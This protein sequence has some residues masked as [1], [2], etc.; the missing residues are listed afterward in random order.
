MNNIRLCALLPLALAT[1]L[2][3]A[4]EPVAV[5]TLRQEIALGDAAK[6]HTRLS[7]GDMRIEGTDGGKVEVELT[8]TCT[9]VDPEVCKRRA[10]WVRLAPRMKKRELRVKLKKTPKARLR[11]IQAQMTVRI[12]RQVPVE[13][14]VTAGTLTIRGMQSH[15]NINSGGGDVDVTAVRSGAREVNIDIGFGKADLWLGE[16]RI[17]GTGWPK[18]LNWTG[19]GD[20]DIEIDVVGGGNVSVRLE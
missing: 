18:A 16:E 13:V 5:R 2:P 14:D 11:G 7:I 20:A 1:A 6:V 9:R 15:L 4:A 12:P 10:E 19:I 3:A 8:L 17:K